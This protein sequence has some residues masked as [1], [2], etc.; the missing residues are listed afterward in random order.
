MNDHPFDPS[1][2][3]QNSYS[4]NGRHLPDLAPQES[5]Q[6]ELIRTDLT[7]EGSTPLTPQERDQEEPDLAQRRHEDATATR[8]SLKRLYLS[9][10][11]IGIGLG[12]LV[13]VGLVLLL[14]RFDL[15]NPSVEIREPA[16]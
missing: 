5:E 13:S 16:E 8:R 11:A 9:L 6:Q 15:I 14:D 1:K 12:A 2:P 7:P 4:G 10:L 3:D